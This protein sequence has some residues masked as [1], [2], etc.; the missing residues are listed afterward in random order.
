MLKAL[1]EKRCNWD[2]NQDNLLEKCTAAYH[3][4]DHEFSIIY[5]DY[6]FIEAVIKRCSYG[7]EL[8]NGGGEMVFQPKTVDYELSPYTGL[9]RQ[10]W[11][12]AG[13]YLLQGIFNNIKS[14]DDP[15]V[16]PRKETKVTYPHSADAIWEWKA[17]ILKDWRD[18]SSLQLH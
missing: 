14:F 2:E 6:Y 10:S 9:T 12:E 15:V 18:L 13:E 17:D 16:M 7:N 1:A 4:K 8:V 3:D 5:G 11:I